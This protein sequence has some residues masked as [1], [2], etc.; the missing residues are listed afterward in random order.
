MLLRLIDSKSLSSNNITLVSLKS[1]TNQL[2]EIQNPKCELI[3]LNLNGVSSIPRCL[4]RFLKILKRQRPHIVHSWLYQSDIFSLMFYP[5]L[6][7]ITI[8]WSIRQTNLSFQHNKLFTLACVKI[9]AWFSKLIPDLIIS[10]SKSAIA[11]HESFGYFNEKIIFVPNGVSTDEFKP[12]LKSRKAFRLANA[13]KSE[14]FLVG[15]VARFDSQKDHECFLK[16][17]SL[18]VYDRQDVQF[19]LCGH[20]INENNAALAQYVEQYDLLKNVILGDQQFDIPKVLN[21]LDLLVSSSLGEGWPNVLA[22]AMACGTP[23]VA[24]DVGESVDIVG[25]TGIVVEANNPRLLANGILQMI[26]RVNFQREYLSELCRNHIIEN[27]DI[28]QAGSKFQNVYEGFS[29]MRV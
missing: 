18:I 6:K 28:E 29:G 24:T 20:R 3:Q 27:F 23:C 16:A 15:M 1:V 26:E 4:W 7:G 25:R 10:N 2:L 19:Y 8:I 11:S 13:V 5:F 22:E 12:N 9:L 14:T 21:G 17:A